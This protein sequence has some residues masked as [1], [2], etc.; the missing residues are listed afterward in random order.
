[1]QKFGVAS[2][3]FGD[4][5]GIPSMIETVGML[6][7]FKVSRLVTTMSMKDFFIFFSLMMM[8]SS[9]IVKRKVECF[10]YFNKLVS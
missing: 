10:Y 1:M 6:L 5:L 9:M 8:L 3:P 7:L 2:M 4:V